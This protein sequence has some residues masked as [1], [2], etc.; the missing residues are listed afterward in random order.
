[1]DALVPVAGSAAGATAGKRRVLRAA[2]VIDGGGWS[3]V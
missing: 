2:S 1:M 3:V